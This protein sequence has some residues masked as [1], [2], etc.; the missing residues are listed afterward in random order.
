MLTVFTE[1]VPCDRYQRPSTIT[2]HSEQQRRAACV[3]YPQRAVREIGH[4]C[5]EGGGG[6]DRRPIEKGLKSLCQD[7]RDDQHDERGEEEG[8]SS[9]IAPVQRHRDS[10]AAGLAKRGGSYLDEPETKGDLWDLAE[11]IG[12]GAHAVSSHSARAARRA[13]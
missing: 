8:S 13:M 12:H 6:D 4:G 1:M 10:I 2:R 11:A 5:A 9:E 7:L 3:T